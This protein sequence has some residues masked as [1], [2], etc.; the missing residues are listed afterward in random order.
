MGNLVIL[1]ILIVINIFFKVSEISIL[2][3]NENKI[4]QLVNKDENKIKRI[5][6]LFNNSTNILISIRVGIYISSFLISIFLFNYFIN[7][8]IINFQ[9]FNLTISNQLLKVIIV[10]VVLIIFSYIS[11]VFGELI[12]KQVVIKRPEKMLKHI[13]IPLSFITI[14]TKPFVYFINVSTNIIVKLFKIDLVDSKDNITEEEIRTLVDVG[15]EKGAINTSEKYMI[16]NIFEFNDKTVGDIMTHRTEM[17]SLD[18]NSDLKELM[19]IINENQYSRYPVYKDQ[20]DNVIGILNV[21]DLLYL[22]EDNSKF[23][24]EKLIRKAVYIPEIKNLSDAFFE[25]QNSNTHIAIVIDEYGGTAGIVTIEDL[26]EEIVGNIFDEY[27]HEEDK[28]VKEI[29]KNLYEVSGLISL[30]ELGRLLNVEFPTD[31]HETLSGL[32]INLIGNIPQ[33]GQVVEVEFNNLIIKTLK[34]TDK[35][36]EKVIIKVIDKDNEIDDKIE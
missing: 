28:E 3:T 25:L 12:L 34:V 27:D 24:L 36:I 8:L 6:N 18:I 23:K 13:S 29:S 22:I 20:L 11:I 19:E 9:T 26:L 1:I 10:I 17:V 32:L 15:E 33:K 7:P 35:I 14:L 2:S 4:R 30:Y 21:K 16:N 31:E 5:I